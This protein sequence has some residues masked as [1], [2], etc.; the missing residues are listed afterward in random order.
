[1][2]LRIILK[3]IF[4]FFRLF[5]RAAKAL[6][7]TAQVGT[8]GAEALRA[9]DGKHDD[10]DDQQLRPANVGKHPILPGQSP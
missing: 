7:C 5:H 8:Q 2:K 10:Q 9:E 6:H 4:F 3:L 1:M